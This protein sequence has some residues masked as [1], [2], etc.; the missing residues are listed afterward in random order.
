[1]KDGQEPSRPPAVRRA[2]PT[3]TPRGVG[4][5]P[6]VPAAADPGG[7]GLPGSGRPPRDGS[8][9]TAFIHR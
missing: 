5:R 9:I 8:L 3:P 7:A 4:A 1:M 6:A 2:R